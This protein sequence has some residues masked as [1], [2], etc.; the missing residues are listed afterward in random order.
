[1]ALNKPLIINAVIG[2]V[3][4]PL[5]FASGCATTA[6][7]QESDLVEAYASNLNLAQKQQIESKISSWFG[8]VKITLADDVF[9]ESSQ[10]SIERKA[11][12]DERRLPIEGRHNNPAF[13]F[14]L[15]TDGKHCILR[16]NQT[17]ETEMLSGVTCK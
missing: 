11:H 5:A 4:I 12:M 7:N 3:A 13:T 10:V 17:G 6:P 8:G 9:S 14:T 1:M 2:L 16:N 15:L